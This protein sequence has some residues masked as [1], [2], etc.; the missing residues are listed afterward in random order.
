MLPP[1]LLG[2]VLPP[3]SVD[4]SEEGLIDRSPSSILNRGLIVHYSIL[5]FVSEPSSPVPYGHR[6]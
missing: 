3:V 6:V 1:V 5:F 4:V 2:Y